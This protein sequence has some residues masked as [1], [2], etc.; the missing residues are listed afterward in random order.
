M[1]KTNHL[2]TNHWLLLSFFFTKMIPQKLKIDIFEFATI[3]THVRLQCTPNIIAQKC[4]K[5]TD[6]R[7][8]IINFSSFGHQSKQIPKPSQISNL[9]HIKKI[10]KI[11]HLIHFL[12]LVSKQ[13]PITHKITTWKYIPKS[14]KFVTRFKPPKSARH[15]ENKR[16]W[17]K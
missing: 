2:L 10:K 1:S 7:Y 15:K 6:Y 13:H 9:S 5:N 4:M 14:P 3:K 17:K 16:K 8:W 12:P 11:L